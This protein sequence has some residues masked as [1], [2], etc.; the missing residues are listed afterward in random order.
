MIAL[1]GSGHWFSIEL[2]TAL[3]FDADY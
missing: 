3:S 2:K 1:G